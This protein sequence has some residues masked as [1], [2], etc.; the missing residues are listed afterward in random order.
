MPQRHQG[1]IQGLKSP[2]FRPVADPPSLSAPATRIALGMPAYNAGRQALVHS[3]L[4][5]GVLNTTGLF[6]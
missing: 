1:A 3:G 2:P 6:P 4:G 5:G